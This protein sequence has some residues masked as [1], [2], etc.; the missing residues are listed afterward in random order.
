VLEHRG[1][2]ELASDPGRRDLGLGEAQEID[3]VAKIGHTALRPGLAGDDVHERGLA[4]PVRADQATQL[5]VVHVQREPVQGLEAVEGDG[6]VLNVE[7][8]PR[9]GVEHRALHPAEAILHE[10]HLAVVCRGA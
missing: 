8:G 4:R 7:D 5:A 1:A 10:I 6:Q 3:V 2:L 9:P